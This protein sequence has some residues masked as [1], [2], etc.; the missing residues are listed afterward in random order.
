MNDGPRPPAGRHRHEAGGAAGTRRLLWALL[1]AS[2]FGLPPADAAPR[3]PGKGGLDSTLA[4][5]SDFCER[6]ASRAAGTGFPIPAGGGIS[7]HDGRPPALG[8]PDLVKR[9]ADTQ[10][11]GRLASAD[12][13]YLHFLAPGGDVWAVVYDGM[14]AC[15]VMVTGAAGD[16]PAAAARLADSL[17]RNG[18]QSAGSTAAT[19][20]MPLAQHVL[21]KQVPKAGAP[22]LGLRLRIRALSGA[23]AEPDGVQLELGFLAGEVGTSS[24]DP[25]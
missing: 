15:D 3:K 4:R 20:T 16:M 19:A 21:V 11:I 25:Q 9:F 2:L 17:R 22:A 23:A 6:A 13:F 12:R 18:W 5:A 10:P 1:A 24:P 7:I 8:T 14:P